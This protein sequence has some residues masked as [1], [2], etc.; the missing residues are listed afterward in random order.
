MTDYLDFK[1][2][3]SI[4]LKLKNKLSMFYKGIKDCVLKQ[5]HQNIFQGKRMKTFHL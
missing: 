1:V 5:F 4:C 3:P 2:E